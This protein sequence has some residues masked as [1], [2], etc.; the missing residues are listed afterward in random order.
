MVVRHADGDS[1]AS[2]VA[3][4]STGLARQLGIS[5]DEFPAVIPSLARGAQVYQ[6]NCASCHGTLGHGNGPAATGMNPPPADLANTVSLRAV[7]PLDFYQKVTIGV[8]GTAMPAFETRL[9]SEDRW[10]AAAY[11][12]LLRLPAPA[13][14]VPPALRAF[15]TSGR[16]SDSALAQAL[17]PA[18]GDVNDPAVLARWPQ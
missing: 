2:R 13:G 7:T 3:I 1:V 8:T 4:F 9:S 17:A 12:T 15:A 5:L 16:M 6:A 10:A 18:G 14:E 11:V